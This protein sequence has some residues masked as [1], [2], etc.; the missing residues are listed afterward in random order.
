MLNEVQNQGAAAARIGLTIW[1]CPYLH[2]NAMPGHT[3]EHF[4]DWNAKLQ[5]WEEGWNEASSRR[6]E[7]QDV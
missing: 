1:D 3:G 7:G 5:A 6:V 2:A 4:W